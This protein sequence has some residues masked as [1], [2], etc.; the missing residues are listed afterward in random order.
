MEQPYDREK[1]VDD[2]TDMITALELVAKLHAEEM[3][4]NPGNVVIAAKTLLVWVTIA[5]AANTGRAVRWLVA[6]RV[7]YPFA[8]RKRT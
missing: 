4:D 2:I 5:I 1:H 3:S 7:L 8:D 6:N